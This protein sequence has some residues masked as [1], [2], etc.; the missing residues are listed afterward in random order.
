MSF[1][2]TLTKTVSEKLNIWQN[3]SLFAKLFSLY[4]PY[5]GAGVRVD[6][7]D[8]HNHHISVSMPLTKLNQNIVGTQFGGSL[9]AMTD[10]FFMTLL[11][12]ALGKD[13]VV[14][15][16]SASIDFIKAGKS[17]VTADFWMT[18]DEIATIKEL[19]KDGSAV[20]RDYV[21]DIKDEN[22]E[23]IAKVDKKLYIRLREFSKSKNIN[24]RF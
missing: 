2:T 3:P 21:V 14:W 7:I 17:K 16:K 13:Y 20:F 8:F 9:Y 19:A 22:G 11:M 12:N 6:K 5:L 15:D 4:A 1:I 18:H 24:P 10:P 23:V